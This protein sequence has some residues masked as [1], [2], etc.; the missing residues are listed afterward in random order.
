M[1]SNKK[2]ALMPG[3]T[4][5]E[6]LLVIVVIAI[7]ASISTVVYAG[8]QNKAKN[9]SIA[10]G[11]E[12]Y[13]K[14]MELYRVEYGNYPDVT[15]T[16]CLGTADGLP[17]TANFSAGQCSFTDGEITHNDRLNQVL[18]P[19]MSSI[20]NIGYTDELLYTKDGSYYR[21]VYYEGFQWNNGK[22]SYYYFEYAIKSG[23]GKCPVGE[24]AW[25]MHGLKL[26]YIDKRT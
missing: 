15:A 26:C 1:T 25:D 6:L 20:P 23:T 14:A 22:N 24:E 5:V 18:A 19:Y 13:M 7:L 17:A 12:S 11:I 21:G 16:T 8:I 4:I 2:V 3:F 9:T 10:A